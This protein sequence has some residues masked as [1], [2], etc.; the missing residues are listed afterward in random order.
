MDITKLERC[1]VCDSDWISSYIPQESID[2]GFYGK[3]S[4][5]FSRVWG[6]EYTGSDRISHYQCPDCDSC[7]DRS[8]KQIFI[9]PVQLN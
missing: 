3:D 1:P 5:F 2:K 7:W 8:G 4:K 9:T 6:I